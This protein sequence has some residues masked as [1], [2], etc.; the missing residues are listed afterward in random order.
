M[1]CAVDRMHRQIIGDVLIE[2]HGITSDDELM[3]EARSRVRRKLQD[4]L[5]DDASTKEMKKSCRNALLKVLWEDIKQRPMVI[6][7]VLE[8]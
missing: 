1:A 8:A 2:M 5:S 7:N 3:R 4:A 6:V